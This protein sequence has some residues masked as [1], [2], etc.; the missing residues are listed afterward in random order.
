M[1]VRLVAHLAVA[2]AVEVLGT[3]H[4]MKVVIRRSLVHVGVASADMATT[5]GFRRFFVMQQKR[6]EPLADIDVHIVP[7]RFPDRLQV[8]RSYQMRHIQYLAR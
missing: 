6:I 4:Q 5:A 8:F 2:A 3:A 1:F 7:R